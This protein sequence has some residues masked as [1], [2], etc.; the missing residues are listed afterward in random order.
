[1]A[2]EAVKIIFDFFVFPSLISKIS[3][4]FLDIR[5]SKAFFEEF[6]RSALGGNS[7]KN[8]AMSSRWSET[9]VF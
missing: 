3:K 9:S 7:E 6:A 4:H 5:F 2:E 1:M 8:R